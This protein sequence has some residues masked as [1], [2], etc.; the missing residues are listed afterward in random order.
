MSRPRPR[1]AVIAERL[2]E[3]LQDDLADI[4]STIDWIDAAPVAVADPAP[5]G[6]RDDAD[7]DPAPMAATPLDLM[8]DDF[9]SAVDAMFSAR[10]EVLTIQGTADGGSGDC[11]DSCDGNDRKAPN[12]DALDM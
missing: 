10:A 11:P 2:S 1:G 5:A 4:A 8:L 12:E 3:A 6:N 7:V 9:A